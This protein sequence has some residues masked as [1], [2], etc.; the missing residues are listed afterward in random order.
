MRVIAYFPHPGVE[1]GEYFGVS[2]S[3]Y[4]SDMSDHSPRGRSVTRPDM[5]PVIRHQSVDRAGRDMRQPDTVTRH[6]RHQSVDRLGQDRRSYD[7]QRQAMVLCDY[8][9]KHFTEVSGQRNETGC[10]PF[11]F[12]VSDQFEQEHNCPGAGGN[13]A[14]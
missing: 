2:S 1:N 4:H 6:D 7:R 8:K 12:F 14:L 13:A 5:T 10:Q 11:P 3:D 9:R